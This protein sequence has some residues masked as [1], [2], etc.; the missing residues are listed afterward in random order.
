M[1]EK[2]NKT[3]NI[4]SPCTKQ[5][6]SFVT[7]QFWNPKALKIKGINFNKNNLAATPTRTNMKLSVVSIYPTCMNTHSFGVEI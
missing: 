1:K 4:L 3:V 6:V 7:V 2:Q 5:L